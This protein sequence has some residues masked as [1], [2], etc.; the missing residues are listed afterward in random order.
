MRKEMGM[1]LKVRQQVGMTSRQ[2][3]LD[4]HFVNLLHKVTHRSKVI[5]SMYQTVSW[6]QCVESWAGLIEK[7]A[8]T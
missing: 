2:A 5:I 3:N 1:T 6:F 4:V 8:D 7:M